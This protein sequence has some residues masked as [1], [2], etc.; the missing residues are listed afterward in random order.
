MQKIFL[1]P[2]FVLVF[3]FSSMAA[4]PD[5]PTPPGLS[6]DGLIIDARGTGFK[7]ALLNRIVSRGGEVLY[8]PSKA[9]PEVV[10][11]NGPAEYTDSI[12]KA[13]AMLWKRGSP[14]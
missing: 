3:A 13:Y 14:R 4:G 8:D 5:L 6:H 9:A 11:Q 7:P 1:I 12:D 10:A 2:F